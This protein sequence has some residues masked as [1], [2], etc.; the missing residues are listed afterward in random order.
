MCSHCFL[1]Y[2]ILRISLHLRTFV[3]SNVTCSCHDIAI[4]LLALNNKYSLTCVNS[5]YF[6][7]S[8]FSYKKKQIH[9]ANS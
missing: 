4:A 3:Q 1:T 7:F 2:E 9:Y 8:V 6:V 5:Y